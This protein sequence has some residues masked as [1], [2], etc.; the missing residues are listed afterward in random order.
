MTGDYE[1]T[2]DRV[3]PVHRWARDQLRVG[4]LLPLHDVV[5]TDGFRAVDEWTGY[6]EAER[7]WREFLGG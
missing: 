3:T 1:P 6:Q 4:G 2:Y 5:T 7:R